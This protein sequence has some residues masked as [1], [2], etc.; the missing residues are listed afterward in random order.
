VNTHELLEVEVGKNLAFLELQEG[1]ESRVGID[2]ATVGSVL[3]VVG[4]DVSIDFSGH[5]SA[6]HLGAKRFAKESGKFVTDLGG[7]DKTRRSTVAT[8]LLSLSFGSSLEFL[9]IIPLN[10]LEDGLHL[11]QLASNLLEFSVELDTT[12]LD[13]VG[14]LSGN[15]LGLRKS[16][17]RHSDRFGGRSNDGLGGFGFLLGLLGLGFRGRRGGG[18]SRGGGRGRGGN[19]GGRSSLD[20]RFGLLVLLCGRLG[21]GGHLIYTIYQ[22]LIFKWFNA[23]NIITG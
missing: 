12:A 4:A 17:N 3:E 16:L 20:N 9:A 18:R 1:G 22:E 2:L 8:L 6:S 10:G 7:L 13:I 19:N 14:S 15:L 21:G 5:I 11:R 23:L